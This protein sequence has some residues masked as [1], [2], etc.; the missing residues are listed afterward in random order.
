MR[1]LHSLRRGF[2]LVELLVVVLIIGALVGIILPAVQSSRESARR[3]QCLNNLKQMGVALHDYHDIHQSLP[4]GCM[5]DIPD[6]I[7]GQG[8]GWAVMLLP[9]L[10]QRPLYDR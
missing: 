5:P 9:H 2:T 8:W 6:P 10:E 4:A 3:A 7:V 1:S